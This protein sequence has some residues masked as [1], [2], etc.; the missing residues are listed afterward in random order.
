M[1]IGDETDEFELGIT[2]HPS[3]LGFAQKQIRRVGAQI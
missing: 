3:S 1:D 2:C